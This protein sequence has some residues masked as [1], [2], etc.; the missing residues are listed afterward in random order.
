MELTWIRLETPFCRQH[1]ATRRALPTMDLSTS[2]QDRPPPGARLTTTD[3][4][5]I[6]LSTSRERETSP[7]IRVTLSSSKTGGE[8]PLDHA[9]ADEPRSPQHRDVEATFLRVRS[10][11]GRTHPMDGHT[12]HPQ[13]SPIQMATKS[14]YRRRFKRLFG[15]WRNRRRRSP[16]RAVTET[17]RWPAGKCGVKS[18]NW[19]LL[20]APMP[21][22]E[23][24]YQFK[25]GTFALA[26]CETRI[27][28]L[29]KPSGDKQPI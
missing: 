19:R 26:C 13:M 27:C 9:G 12:R 8:Q 10:G 6:P 17:I 18:S 29:D 21:V 1:S 4:R 28:C 14:L 15:L 25:P 24:L 5:P 3:A 20:G 16:V 2:G 23:A 11:P 22:V 7:R